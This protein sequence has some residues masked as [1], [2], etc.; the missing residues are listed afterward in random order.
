MS[1]RSA[2]TLRRRLVVGVTVLLGAVIVVVG[3]LSVLTV[4]SSLMGLVDLQ[5]TQSMSGF[6]VAIDKY[7]PNTEP[8]PGEPDRPA[9][10]LVDYTGH[11]PG[12]LIA[13][14]QNGELIDSAYFRESQAA[15]PIDDDVIPLLAVDLPQ[16]PTTVELGALGTYR[17]M[18]ATTALGEVLVVGAPLAA[19]NAAVAAQATTVAVLGML[20]LA[21]T[22]LGGAL[23]VNVA[24]R[25]LRRVVATAM[26]VTTLPLDEGEVVLATRVP[27]ADTDPRTEVGKVGE[28]LNR[29]LG[30]VAAA[31][32]VR[33]E[34]DR[35]IRRFVTDASHE[36]RTPLASIQGYAEL[37]RQDNEQLPD[38]VENSLARIESEARRMTALVNDLLLLA[39]LDEGQDLH[40]ETVDLSRVVVDAVSD[41]H[42]AAPDRDWLLDVPDHSLFVRGDPSR[43]HQVVANLLANARIHTPPGT[44][45]TTTLGLEAPDAVVL[46]I[47]DDGPGIPEDL[48]PV[49]FERFARGDSSRSRRAGSTGLGLAIVASVVQAHGGEVT[50]TS[51]PG[52]TAFRVVLTAVPGPAEPSDTPR[53]AVQA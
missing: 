14:F 47:G 28:A 40:V 8:P 19:V 35:R 49:L 23:V 21:V 17:V 50:V 27:E 52:A 46:T 12:S 44:R 38:L 29:L 43:L 31:L 53:V 7:G 51:K 48:V 42:A 16:R 11:A 34:R 5:L 25:P 36:L 33:E 9:K 2:W 37:T 10:A 20:A 1:A 32:A 3:V 6:E 45:V 22:A 4:R 41:A 15:T 26:E 30:H 13:V 24:L 18:S 39:R